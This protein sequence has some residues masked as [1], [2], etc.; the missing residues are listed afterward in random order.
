LVVDVIVVMAEKGER[1]GD[2]ERR[3]RE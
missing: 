2:D 3:R 1:I